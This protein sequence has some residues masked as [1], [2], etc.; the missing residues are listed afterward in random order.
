MK[1]IGILR[2]TSIMPNHRAPNPIYLRLV[3]LFS[4]LF[5]SVSACLCF[6]AGSDVFGFDQ[7]VVQLGDILLEFIGNAV[8]PIYLLE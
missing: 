4:P 5:V 2:G 7:E 3:D 6:V 8:M 1:G